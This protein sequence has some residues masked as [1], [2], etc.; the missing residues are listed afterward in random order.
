MKYILFVVPL[1]LRIEIVS[2]ACLCVIA[3]MVV[4]DLTKSVV[5]SGRW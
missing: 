3:F 2:Y 1:L 4:Y 5:N